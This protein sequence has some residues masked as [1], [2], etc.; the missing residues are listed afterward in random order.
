MHFPLCGL[1]ALLT[2]LP[3]AAHGANAPE[4][5]GQP[6]CRIA[7]IVPRPMGDAVSW[8]G[9][10]KDGHADGKGVLE[11]HVSGEGKRKLEGTLVRGEISGEG[12][13]TRDLGKYIG[14]FRQGMPHGAGY[15]AYAKS[16]DR[17]E[18]GVVD[19]QR[20][21]AGIMIALD[22][23]VYEGEWK[24]GKRHGRGKATFALG[25]SYDGQ[26]HMGRMHG[27]GTMVYGGSGRIHTGE[28]RNDRAV[29]ATP[30]PPGDYPY[31]GLHEEKAETGYLEKHAPPGHATPMA[32]T[33]EAMTPEQK[34]R[35]RHVYPA[36]DDRDEP[37]YP[38]EGM[39][40]FQKAVGALYRKIPEYEGDG[41][42]YVTVGAD[43]VPTSVTTYGVT[44]QE[45]G[46]YLSMVAMMQR[47]RP[48]RCAGTPCA[49]TFPMRF[50]FTLE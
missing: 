5:L 28:F 25:G 24:A 17:Y 9:A 27:S 13:L 22:G 46:R 3:L 35:A 1:A 33:W 39:G 47:F 49:M 34:N 4:P 48:A 37:P 15:F 30:A 11:W 32:A 23:S 40:A 14:S 41:V 20:E 2:V 18:G 38:L 6:G 16:G 10:C 36:L 8:S 21:G 29:G 19:G 26:W 12:T 42:V 7:D 43:G 31:F 50:L 44:H 45:F